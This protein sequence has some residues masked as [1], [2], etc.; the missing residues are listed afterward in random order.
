MASELEPYL[1]AG[2]AKER[3]NN[4]LYVLLKFA[5]LSPFVQGGQPHSKPRKN[6]SITWRVRGGAN[7]KPRNTRVPVR[8]HR[9]LFP[10]QSSL[11]PHNWKQHDKSFLPLPRWVMDELPWQAGD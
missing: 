10:S 9:R 6:S 7:L 3:Q 11:L 2:T 5:N 1:K 4:A 8:R